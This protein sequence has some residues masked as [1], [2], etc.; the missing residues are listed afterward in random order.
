MMEDRDV[1]LTERIEQRME[2]ESGKG[3][4]KLLMVA[5]GIV[6]TALL[7]LLNFNV[8]D[9]N[10]IAAKA[11]ATAEGA[12]D[13]NYKQERDIALLNVK[14]ESIE[15]KTDATVA[16]LQTLILQVTQNRD[17]IEHNTKQSLQNQ[18]PGH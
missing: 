4:S 14:T 18:R 10:A 3:A 16:G 7:G 17:A 8:R 9:S 12:R 1:R 2:S 15:R 6:T 5:F 11:L 13:T